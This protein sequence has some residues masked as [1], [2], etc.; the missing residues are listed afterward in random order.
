LQIFHTKNRWD[1]ENFA[2]DAWWYKFLIKSYQ[3]NWSRSP[4]QPT[5]MKGSH[6]NNNRKKNMKNLNKNTEHLTKGRYEPT[7]CR[8]PRPLPGNSDIIITSNLVIFYLN[9]DHQN[10]D[11]TDKII[12]SFITWQWDDPRDLWQTIWPP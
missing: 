10:E 1:I 12:S 9:P 3:N 2:F 11:A 8:S 4:A 7:F 6:L 5:S